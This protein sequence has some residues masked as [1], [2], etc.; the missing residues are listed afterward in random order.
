M[1]DV[2]RLDRALPLPR[3]RLVVIIGLGVGIFY[4]ILGF[5]VRTTF[6]EAFKVPSASMAPTIAAG[7]QIFVRKGRGPFQ[8]GDV[9]AFRYPLDPSLDYVKRV[10]GVGGDVVSLKA[11]QLLVNGQPVTR[12]RLDEPCGDDDRSPSP[13]G[14]PGKCSLWEES[15][16]GRSWRVELD[17]DLPLRDFGTVVVPAGSYF[18]LGDNRDASSDSRVWGFLAAELI[19]GTASFTWWSSG[20]RGVRWAR[21]DQPV[22]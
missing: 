3:A 20:E 16:E 10:I 14:S 22:R 5:R 17:D 15:F 8:R 2:L 4:E 21:I 13:I 7:D 11:E 6:V 9:I 12:R 19:K 18:V 1:V